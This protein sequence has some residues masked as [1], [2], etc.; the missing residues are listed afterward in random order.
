MGADGSGMREHPLL[1]S[2]LHASTE[3]ADVDFARRQ[4]DVA[5]AWDSELADGGAVGWRRFD[6]NEGRVAVSYPDVRWAQLRADHGWAALH[7]Q[8]VMRTSMTIPSV[9]APLTPVRLDVINGTEFAVVPASASASGGPDDIHWYA[10]DTYGFALTPSGASSGPTSNFARTLFLTPG[11]SVLLVRAAFEIRLFG[12]PGTAPPTINLEVRAEVDGGPPVSIQAGAVG[13]DAVDGRIMGEW[14]GVPV[15]ALVPATVDIVPGGDVVEVLPG[16][17]VSLAPAQVRVIAVR[18]N[19]RRRVEPGKAITIKLAVSLASGAHTDALVFVYTPKHVELERAEPFQIT[20]AS[21]PQPLSDASSPASV[22][23]A[24]VVPPSPGAAS[25]R[26]RP[27]LLALHGAGVD[28][29]AAAWT[30][31]LPTAHTWAVLANGKNEWGED[32]HGA[33]MA[34]SWAAREAFDRVVS[35]LGKEC[36]TETVLLGHSNGGQGAWHLAARYPD[37]IAGL[38]VASGWLKIQDYVPYTELT[39]AHYADPALMGVLM[40][41]LTPYNNDLYAS[42]LAHVPVLAIHG[43]ADTNVPPRHGRAHAGLVRAWAGTRG[44]VT[45]VELEGKDHWWDDMFRDRRVAEWLD[46]LPPKLSVD[47]VRKKGFTLTSANP[48]E[49]GAK[50][51]IRIAE[52]DVPGRLA[53][54]DV[55]ARQWRSGRTGDLDLHG[56]NIRRIEL[57]AGGRVETLSLVNGE[58]VPAPPH[59]ARAYGPLIRIL[60][61]AGPMVVVV[62]PRSAHQAR[63]AARVAHDMFVYHRTDAE[64]VEAREALERVARNELGAGSVVVIGRPEENLFAQWLVAQ[65]RVPLAFPARGVFT[66]ADKLVYEAGTGIITLYPHPTNSAGL[67]LLIAGNDTDGLESAARLFPLRTGV[68]VPDWAVVSARW[69][70]QAAGGLV[71]AG[72]WDADWAWSAHSWMDR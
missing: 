57:T 43:G 24:T 22:A 2:P 65:K 33:S 30:A 26:P 29:A 14:I 1:A 31:A 53:R 70:W 8:V 66:L 39:S 34:E 72:F 9:G 48:D 17:T 47:E 18:I 6:A 28:P 68:P 58:L 3:A 67:A 10:A 51:G 11:E 32:W 5:D 13:P 62:D 19:Q 15:R 25:T 12:D 46:A 23:R 36:G 50:A 4:Y 16:H 61:T 42:N 64:I 56:S 35:A 49:A 44:D 60:A 69:K 21:P 45:Y 37:K 59:R 7:F 40:S 52:L 63:L 71:G 55:N 20:F 54:L 41:A 27:V 38:I